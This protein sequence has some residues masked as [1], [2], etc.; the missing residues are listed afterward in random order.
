MIA[1]S[2]C[3]SDLSPKK[4]PADAFPALFAFSLRRKL[5]YLYS[6]QY[7][8]FR[9]DT[10]EYSY[11]ET[12]L[13]GDCYLVKI[14]DQ[15]ARYPLNPFD[16]SQEDPSKQ[17]SLHDD[18]DGV[19]AQF[20][21][22]KYLDLVNDPSPHITQDFTITAIGDGDI[23]R[24]M[25]GIY[26]DQDFITIEPGNPTSRFTFN[27]NFGS[28]S[29]NSNNRINQLFSGIE[30]RQNANRVIT[31]KSDESGSG[32]NLNSDTS[33]N[34]HT[35]SIGRSG[36]RGFA[37]TFIEATMHLGDATK[38]SMSQVWAEAKEVY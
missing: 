13:S 37:G 3:L 38:R 29:K 25:V 9:N 17:P 22:G 34:F 7:F 15:K 33:T 24:P 26:G 31:M 32:Q 1:Y 28:V 23:P 36:D 12:P 6:G 27:S 5:R 10:G 30:S 35:I 18:G 14:Y 21:L 11:P 19:Y 4:L 16:A 8:R 2:T 20:E